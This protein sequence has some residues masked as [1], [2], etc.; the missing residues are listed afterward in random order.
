[1]NNTIG[2]SDDYATQRK[3]CLLAQKYRVGETGINLISR[4]G[5]TG[6]SEKRIR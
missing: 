2:N 6:V 5:E 3:I 4:E 1:M